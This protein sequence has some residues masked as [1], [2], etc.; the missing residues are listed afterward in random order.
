[1]KDISGIILMPAVMREIW[2]NPS[3]VEDDE[4]CLETCTAYGA[5]LERFAYSEE[6]RDREFYEQFRN[7]ISRYSLIFQKDYSLVEFITNEQIDYALA[8]VK[9]ARQEQLDEKLADITKAKQPPEK[10]SVS[11]RT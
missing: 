5:A 7:M 1:M 2:R 6:K 3:I 8:Q 10:P 9:E 11:R 4:A